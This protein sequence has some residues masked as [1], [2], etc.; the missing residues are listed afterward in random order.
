MTHSVQP[1]S[2]PVL[3]AKWRLDCVDSPTASD[4]VRPPDTRHFAEACQSDPR[5]SA[6]SS[7]DLNGLQRFPRMSREKAAHRAAC[8]MMMTCSADAARHFSLQRAAASAPSR[9]VSTDRADAPRST[10]GDRPRRRESLESR[11][12]TLL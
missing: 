10:G 6:F 3:C 8:L 1:K 12:E 9:H 11:Y 5:S 4:V 7:S 2:V